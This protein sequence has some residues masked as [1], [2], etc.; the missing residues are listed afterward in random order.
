M[1]GSWW[2]QPFAPE[3][4]ATA[5]GI[6]RQLGRPGL[7]ELTI[8]VREAAQNS[9]DARRGDTVDFAVS[10]EKLGDRFR[11]WEAVGLPPRTLPEIQLGP[12]SWIIRVSD[13]GTYGLRG[14]VR[15]SQ[16]PGEDEGN[17]FVQFLR[18]VGEPRDSELG[19]GTYGFG[20]GIFYRLSRAAAI[21]VDSRVQ[22]THGLERRI[23]GAALG[24]DFYEEDLRYTGRHWWGRIAQ[25]EI[26]DP[27]TGEQAEALAAD[28]GLPGF[29]GD[30]TGSDIIVLLPDFGARAKD[31][32][33]APLDRTAAEAADHVVSA[34]LWNLWPKMGGE[35]PS[36]RFTVAVDGKELIVPEPSRIPELRPFVHALGSI[37]HG[38]G[39]EYRRGATVIG[40]FHAVLFPSEIASR[41]QFAEAK[42]FLGSPKHVAR[43][44][45][46][47]LVVDYIEGE[48]EIDP[49]YGYGAV[50]RAGKDVDD[51]F[52][53][54][55]PPT[56]DQWIEQG[57][58]RHDLS[59]VRG[60]RIWIRARLRALYEK[61]T[62]NGDAAPGLGGL[63]SR[64]ASLIPTISATGASPSAPRARGG[65]T[66]GKGT[67]QRARILGEPTVLFKGSEPYVFARVELPSRWRTDRLRGDARVVLEGG[68]REAEPPAGERVPF[69]VG[70]ET[71]EGARI[72]SG[73]ELRFVDGLPSVVHLVGAFVPDAVLRLSVSEVESD[74]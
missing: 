29:A 70:W 40:E 74:A 33:E 45:A 54:A 50:F 9:W 2:S 18:N 58:D 13:R 37:R 52:A 11:A 25:D 47:E 63:A 65:S 73:P 24:E 28:L 72:A 26:P 27:L 38:A 66:G 53:N 6:L 10:F 35:S 4:S 16:R 60:A 57:L 48:V 41:E 14:P 17:D 56:H 34:L 51:T 71:L 19:G 22:T 1:S 42:P 61:T 5:G 20:K 15:A 62:I 32:S 30:D 39:L 64:L 8:L 49:A 21:L 12:E 46:A 67:S 43:M 69:I 55:E 23:M 7:D 36:M 68:G 31:D 44:R 59:I 3:G